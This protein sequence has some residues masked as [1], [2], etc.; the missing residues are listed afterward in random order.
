[1]R[2]PLNN[3]NVTQIEIING[4]KLAAMICEDKQVYLIDPDRNYSIVHIM[5]NPHRG[6][7]KFGMDKLRN[8]I[9]CISTDGML[10]FYS[11][12]KMLESGIKNLKNKIRAGEE[13]DKIQVL[14]NVKERGTFE[15]IADKKKPKSKNQNLD[16]NLDQLKSESEYGIDLESKITEIRE[17]HICK[18]EKDNFDLESLRTFI[19]KNKEYPQKYRAIIWTHLLNL[20]LNFQCYNSYLKQ[21]SNDS[22]KHFGEKFPLKSEK[23]TQK[24][25]R[26]LTTLSNYSPIFRDMEIVPTCV[27]PIVKLFS[28][29]E[30]MAFEVSLSFF[31]H[32]GQFI[33]EDYPEASTSVLSYVNIWLT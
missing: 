1:M 25:K 4:T 31:Q 8:S 3:W 27:F 21:K 15:G 16:Q 2:L 26:V 23:L 33:F 9:A 17:N 7:I 30:C 29:D 18:R 24:M 32:W 28:N 6:F 11:M 20:P 10:Y 19:K 5:K 12:P 13:L 22:L 14:L